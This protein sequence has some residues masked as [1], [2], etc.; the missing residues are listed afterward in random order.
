[1]AMASSVALYQEGQ[2][3]YMGKSRLTLGSVAIFDNL[4]AI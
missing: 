1:M 4:Y 3:D 2:G